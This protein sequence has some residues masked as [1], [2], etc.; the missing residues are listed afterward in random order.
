LSTSF[1]SWMLNQL[2][3]CSSCSSLPTM[4]WNSMGNLHRETEKDQKEE[5]EDSVMLGAC[6]DHVLCLVH[7]AHHGVGQHGEPA[8]ERQDTAV[9]GG[10]FVS[11]CCAWCIRGH[12]CAWCMLPTMEQSSMVHLHCGT[13][14]A[15]WGKLCD[16][17]WLHFGCTL[18]H[19]CTTCHLS[20]ISQ[21]TAHPVLPHARTSSATH[22]KAVAQIQS[23]MNHESTGNHEP[24][25]TPSRGMCGTHSLFGS[26][27][28]C[29]SVC[30][31]SGV[32]H[33]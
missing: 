24:T 1:A 28:Q 25:A 7:V 19:V 10:M 8:H 4:E 11:M 32:A 2:G 3:L 12:C 22:R 26:V 27:S 5:E 20:M 18:T 30:V 29:S 16:H 33:A 9:V 31:M 15:R 17:S 21:G 14:K 13:E 6:Y 23:H